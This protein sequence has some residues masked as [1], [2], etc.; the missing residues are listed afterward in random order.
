MRDVV[1]HEWRHPSLYNS[2]NPQA[3]DKRYLQPRFVQGCSF[4]YMQPVG[5]PGGREDRGAAGWLRET[6]RGKSASFTKSEGAA[7]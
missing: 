2:P 6:E 7:K 1:N 5:E 4:N 3:G